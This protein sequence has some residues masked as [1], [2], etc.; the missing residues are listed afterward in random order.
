VSDAVPPLPPRMLAQALTVELDYEPVDIDMVVSGSPGTG[1]VDFGTWMGLDVG[2]WEMTEGAMRDI[3][4]EEVFV[5]VAGEATLT[6][7]CDGAP[8]TVELRPGVVCHL[9]EG[10]D[11]L[12]EVRSPLR[13]IYFA[14]SE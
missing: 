13:K 3:E 6:R 9:E 11:N 10:E 1:Y 5:V 7:S 14:P 4:V 8:E 12:W 2:V